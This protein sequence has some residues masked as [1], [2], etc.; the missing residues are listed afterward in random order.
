MKSIESCKSALVTFAGNRGTSPGGEALSLSQLKVPDCHDLCQTRRTAAGG[1]WKKHCSIAVLFADDKDPILIG[2]EVSGEGDFDVH[3][4]GKESDDVWEERKV[5]A[6]VDLYTIPGTK[7]TLFDMKRLK[8]CDSGNSCA[9]A[10]KAYVSA[11][12]RQERLEELFMTRFNTYKAGTH[13]LNADDGLADGFICDP[14]TEGA[15]KAH[16]PSGKA[17]CERDKYGVPAPGTC[18]EDKLMTAAHERAK[19][20]GW[21][22]YGLVMYNGAAPCVHSQEKI[23]DFLA[24]HFFKKGDEINGATEEHDWYEKEKKAHP[25][26]FKPWVAP[27]PQNGPK[28]SKFVWT[29]QECKVDNYLGDAAASK[30]YDKDHLNA[31]FYAIK[32]NQ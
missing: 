19:K 21:P 18:S 11:H 5:W 2:P 10:A 26:W 20:E 6:Q 29:F 8:K 12:P 23:F 3:M 24:A 25:N 1:A 16:Q 4:T 14:K 15:K 17:Y 7:R 9:K 27:G 28:C 22:T 30:N 31:A 32:E 13:F